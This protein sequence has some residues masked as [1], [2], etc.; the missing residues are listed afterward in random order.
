MVTAFGFSRFISEGSP[1]KVSVGEETDGDMIVSI[2][3]EF[4]HIAAT[5]SLNLI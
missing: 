3:E 2:R 1:S 4:I 5:K